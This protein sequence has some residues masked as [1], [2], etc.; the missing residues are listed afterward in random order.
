MRF[1]LR[2]RMHGI[3][4]DVL[5]GLLGLLRGLYGELLRRLRLQL[6]GRMPGKLR[7]RVRIGLYGNLRQH[8][9]IG[10]RNRMQRL[11]KQ[12]LRRMYGLRR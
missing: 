7:L 1:R 12:L 9:H 4:R 6:L 8:L 3:L 5:L 11:W 2:Q 10:L